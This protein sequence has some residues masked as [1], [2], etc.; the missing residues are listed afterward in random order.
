M[1][2]LLHKIR[3]R[4]GL[5]R[6]AEELGPPVL[7][8]AVRF[9]YGPFQFKFRVVKGVP[10]E[11]EATN[12]LKSWASIFTGV[13]AGETEFLDSDAS[14]FSYRFYRLNSN[15]LYSDKVIGYASITL[16]PGFTMVGNPLVGGN[17][18][19]QELFKEM[20]QGTSVSKFDSR[21]HQLRE[22]TFNGGKWTNPSER[23]GHGE[24]AI[25]FNPSL[26]YKSLTFVGEVKVGSYSI[27]V[28]A[29]FTIQTSSV[30]EPGALHPDLRFPIDDGDVIH[31]FDR[32][33]QKYVLYPFVGNTWAAGQPVIGV[34]ES[35]WVAKRSPRNW[36]LEVPIEAQ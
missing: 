8:S 11:I 9:P 29:G 16:A 7:G 20:P 26:D 27:P 2:S 15:G 1:R 14:K 33:Q 13:A 10:Y 22:N 36:A 34:A 6:N 28:P 25:V 5:G 4:A 17:D 23:I 35:F 31:L 3:A 30:P 24:G 21:L 19:V 18:G 32:D 12:N